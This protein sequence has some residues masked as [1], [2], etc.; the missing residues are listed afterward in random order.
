MFCVRLKVFINLLL[1]FDIFLIVCF[2][3]CFGINVMNNIGEMI[4]IDDEILINEN[5]EFLKLVSAFK[6]INMADNQCVSKSHNDEGGYTHVS[7]KRLV[8]LDEEQWQACLPVLHELQ[9]KKFKIGNEVPS[10]ETVYK[11]NLL[12]SLS[13][14][15][16]LV[17]KENTAD[18][19]C[20]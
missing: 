12:S 5:I 3:Y 8:V 20:V 17:C 9:C 15:Y 19:V 4:D 13:S 11:H 7:G 16:E 1:P 18:I 10:F 2:L 14:S 6:G